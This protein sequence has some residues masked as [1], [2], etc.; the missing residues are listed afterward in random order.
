MVFV[1]A[2]L[3]SGVV[4]ERDARAVREAGWRKGLSFVRGE[5]FRDWA[6]E[7]DEDEWE[8]EMQLVELESGEMTVRSVRV[9]RR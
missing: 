2:L 4:Y 1:A 6:I 3:V 7:D 8:T 9:R 5:G